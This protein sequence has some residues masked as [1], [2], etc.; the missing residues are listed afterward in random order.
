MQDIFN[1]ILNLSIISLKEI[2]KLQSWKKHLGK[3]EKNQA[4]LAPLKNSEIYFLVNFEP[5]KK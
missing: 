1:I 2:E 3:N 4:I 5:Y